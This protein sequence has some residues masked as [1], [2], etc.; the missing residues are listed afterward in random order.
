MVPGQLGTRAD[1]L[2]PVGHSVRPA[3]T[4]TTGL[5]SLKTTTSTAAS[6]AVGNT[7]SHLVD[8]DIVLKRTY[9]II[10]HWTFVNWTCEPTI[11]ARSG[12]SPEVHAHATR[13]AIG[14]GGE[15]G[16][17][18]ARRVLDGN[19]NAVVAFATRCDVGLLE[20]EGGFGETVLVRNVVDRVD[21]VESIHDRG[22]LLACSLGVRSNLFVSSDLYAA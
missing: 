15:V 7:M 1:L 4:H 5:G 22:V 13:G 19:G 20:V 3:L 8:N 12:G 2:H 16:I 11:T 10:R 18:G 17:V 9:V 14:R 21:D 6:H